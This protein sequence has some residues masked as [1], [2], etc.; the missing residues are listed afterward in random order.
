MQQHLIGHILA[1]PTFITSILQREDWTRA[2]SN[3]G[4]DQDKTRQDK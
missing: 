1:E 3:E 2:S 4:L